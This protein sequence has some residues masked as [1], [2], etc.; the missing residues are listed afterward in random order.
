MCGDFCGIYVKICSTHREIIGN[1]KVLYILDYKSRIKTAQAYSFYDCGPHI[2]ILFSIKWIMHSCP[3][4]SANAAYLLKFEPF[5]GIFWRHLFP[6]HL[7]HTK[8]FL[9]SCYVYIIILK[10]SLL[11]T[12]LRNIGDFDGGIAEKPWFWGWAVT[13]GGHE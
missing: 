4:W 7:T 6:Y 8:Y 10:G 13:F 5:W 1:P 9:Y 12:L 3:V 11:L 2:Y